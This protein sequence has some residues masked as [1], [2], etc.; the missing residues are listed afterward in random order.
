MTNG[1]PGQSAESSSDAQHPVWPRN[2]EQPTQPLFVS[3]NTVEEKHD[4]EPKGEEEMA[5][6]AEKLVKKIEELEARV[7]ME[8]EEARRPLVV[9]VPEGP[10]KKRCKSIWLRIRR[11]NHGAHIA[12]E[13]EV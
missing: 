11:P 4:G 8:E 3:G 9:K 5:A 1:S 10:L 12:Q 13:H 6:H 2:R 7:S